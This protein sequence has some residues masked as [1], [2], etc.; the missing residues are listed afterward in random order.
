MRKFVLI[1]SLLLGTLVP[2]RQAHAQDSAKPEEAGHSA[3]AAAHFYRVTFLVEEM[4]ANEKATNSRTYT[5]TISTDRGF[6]GSI[7]TGSRIPIPT[8]ITGPSGPTQFQYVDTGI[9]F[10]MTNVVEI[11]RQLSLNLTAEISSVADAK[12]PNL[13]EPVIRQNRWQA[14]VLIPIGKA[15]VIFASDALDSATK[16]RVSMTATPLP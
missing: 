15:S 11:D 4:G 3:A 8:G 16:L 5:T 12:E 13:H 2:L 6:K 9:N 14:A 10:D 1:C 7:R